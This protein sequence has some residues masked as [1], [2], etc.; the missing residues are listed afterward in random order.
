MEPDPCIPS[1]TA[2]TEYAD[3]SQLGVP[4]SDLPMCL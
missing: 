3:C 1:D 4:F 2:P